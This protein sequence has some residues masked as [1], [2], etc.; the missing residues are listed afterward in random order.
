MQLTTKA[1]V[2]SAL[3]YGDSS[4]IVRAFTASDGLKS[5]MVKGVLASR[6]GKMRAAYFQPLNQL[7]VVAVHRNKGS[8]EFLREVRV[9]FPYSSIHSHMGK[10][11]M[12][13]FLAE[14]LSGS[15]R[16]EERNLPL[17]EYLESAF[18]WLDTHEEIANFHIYFM[19]QLSRYLGFYPDTSRDEL[20][21]FDLVEGEFI[22]AAGA[23]PELHGALLANFKSFLGINFDA[24][25]SVALGKIQ[26]RELLESLLLYFEIHLQEFKKPRSLAVFNEVFS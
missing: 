4:L 20:P 7:E 21:H 26:R 1:I 22:R 24:I 6:R 12:A 10:R 16:E 9:Q 5:Y 11:A 19:L 18:Q 2:I 15:I 14:I 17:F 8:L 25:H 3:K 13:L 23:N